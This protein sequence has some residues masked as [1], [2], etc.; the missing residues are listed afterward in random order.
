MRTKGKLRIEM[1]IKHLPVLALG[2]LVFTF[3][4][5][6]HAVF[7]QPIARIR[8][9]NTGGISD[10][11]PVGIQAGIYKKHGFAVENIL[12]GSSATVVQSLLSGEVTFAHVGAPAVVAAVAGG[13]AIKIIAVFVNR[14]SWILASAPDIRTTRELRGKSIAIARIGSGNEFATREALKKLNLDADKDV[15]LVQVGLTPAR[16][17]ALVSGNVH[18]ALLDRTHILELPKFG[19][20]VLL[21]LNDLDIE[22]A[23]YGLVARENTIV[24]NRP[25]VERFLRAY[26]EGIRYYRSQPEVVMAYLRKNYFPKLSDVEL[27]MIYDGL[28]QGLREDPVPTLGGIQ[29]IIRSLKGQRG[30]DLD[31]RRVIDASFFSGVR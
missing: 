9:A 14:F 23:Q 8:V 2:F 31:P 27:T 25:T 21:D 16:F 15:R 3:L 13:A 28:K 26:V 30:G 17:A 24:E 12:I 4:C 19:L 10:H 7:A 11:L 18:A 29:G 20:N 22:Y 5:L 6:T 1:T